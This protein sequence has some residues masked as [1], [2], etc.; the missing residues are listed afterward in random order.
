MKKIGGFL[1]LFLT[2]LFPLFSIGVVLADLFLK[3]SS[4]SFILLVAG[5]VLLVAGVVY[6]FLR[7]EKIPVVFDPETDEKVFRHLFRVM[8]FSQLLLILDILLKAAQL[9]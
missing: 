1:F 2:A 8:Q 4:V 9:F 3:K 6:T 7:R 5:T